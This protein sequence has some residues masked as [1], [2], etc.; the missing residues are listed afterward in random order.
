MAELVSSDAPD[1]E[2]DEPYTSSPRPAES[3]N[4]GAN[5]LKQNITPFIGRLGG[6]QDCVVDRNDK[7]NADLLRNAPDA[8][9]HMTLAEQLSLKP[10]ANVDL[11]RAAIVEGVGTSNFCFPC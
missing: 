2:K 6:N 9:L 1:L 7:S 5:R 4:N 8:G 10:L 3:V 11:W